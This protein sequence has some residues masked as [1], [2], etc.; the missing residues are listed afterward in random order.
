[1]VIAALRSSATALPTLT[2]PQINASA[3]IAP[4]GPHLQ[5][6]AEAPQR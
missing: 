4:M 3:V 5:H 2:V 1:M 6:I